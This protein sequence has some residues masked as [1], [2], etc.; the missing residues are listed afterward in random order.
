MAQAVQLVLLEHVPQML[1]PPRPRP[2]LAVVEA[3]AAIVHQQRP[4]ELAPLRRP[5]APRDAIVAAA[6]RLAVVVHGRPVGAIG[7]EEGQDV[8]VEHQAAVE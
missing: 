1:W 3:A 7:A 6:G 4:V 5:A 2:P 8:R